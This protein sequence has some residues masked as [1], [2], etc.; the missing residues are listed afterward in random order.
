MF[1]TDLFFFFF[2][3]TSGPKHQQAGKVSHLTLVQTCA[4]R[5]LDATEGNAGAEDSSE[6]NIRWELRTWN[7]AT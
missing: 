2:N 6:V 3:K 1:E 7:M 4:L 5:L